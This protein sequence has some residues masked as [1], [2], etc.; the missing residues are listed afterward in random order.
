[1]INGCQLMHDI[2]YCLIKKDY[3]MQELNFNGRKLGKCLDLKKYSHIQ[4]QMEI[5]DRP[6]WIFLQKNLA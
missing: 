1:M 5:K 4:N 3:D 2:T 6:L